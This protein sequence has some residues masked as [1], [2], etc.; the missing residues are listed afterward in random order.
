MGKTTLINTLVSKAK[1]VPD[2]SSMSFK[3]DDQV[4]GELNMKSKFVLKITIDFNH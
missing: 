4:L 2:S 1:K 3:L